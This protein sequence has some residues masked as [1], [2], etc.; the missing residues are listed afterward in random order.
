MIKDIWDLSEIYITEVF[1]N[2]R[3]RSKSFIWNG[4][5]RF[6]IKK[7]QTVITIIG[8]HWFVDLHMVPG[9]YLVQYNNRPI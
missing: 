1:Q 6:V 7:M 3:D 4:G 8:Y 5:A 2:W 9:R